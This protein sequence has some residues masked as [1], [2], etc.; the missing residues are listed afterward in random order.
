MKTKYYI[1]RI[2]NKKAEKKGERD[3]FGDDC[4]R[5]NV[6]GEG[7]KEKNRETWLWTKEVMSE[8]AKH[9]EQTTSKTHAEAELFITSLTPMDLLF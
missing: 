3:I 7:K 2:I 4:A 9:E 1:I 8:F 5:I 6:E